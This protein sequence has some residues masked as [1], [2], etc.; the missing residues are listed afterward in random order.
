[1]KTHLLAL[2]LAATCGALPVFAQ[3]AKQPA[4]VWG[5]EESDLKPDPKITFGKLGNGMRY[6]ILPNAEPPQRTSLRLYVDAGSLMEVE[7]QRGLAHF[8]EHM[9]FN[10]TTNFP[11]GK[12]VEYFQRLG[13]SF[14]GDTNA[15]TSFKETVYKLE[16]P[17][18]DEKL[19]REGLQLFRDYADGMLLTQDEIEKERGVILS[20]KL[21][22]DSPDSRTMEAAFDFALPDSIIS[23]RLPIGT[24][25]VI[26]GADRDTFV[27]F[28]K[29]W[30]TSD[31]MV[32]VA[33]G[34]VEADKLGPLIE[35]YFSSMKAPSPVVP[36][37]D[38]GK[39]TPGRGAITKI[40]YE[41]EASSTD[42]GIETLR[43]WGHVADTSEQR[44]KDLRMGIA[45][46]IIGRRL[47]KLA[48]EDGAPFLRGSS[49][50]FGFLDFVRFGGIS[51]TCKPDTWEG[52]LQVAEQELRRALQH[53][54]TAAEIDEANAETMSSYRDAAKGAETR[55]SRDLADG[56]VDEVADGIVST[57]PA[58]NLDWVE[59][60]I[61]QVTAA[62]C[63]EE[64]RSL[65]TNQ[66]DVQ[67]FV[68]GNLKLDE[69]E[70]KIAEA[71]KKS[72]A[73]KVEP[74][75]E[76]QQKAFAYAKFGEPGK[77]VETKHHEDLGLTQLRFANNVRLNLKQT[78]FEKDSIHIA[79]RI[80]SGSLTA[81]P[82]RP[83][84][85][86]VASSVFGA[87][88]LVEHSADELQRIFAGNVVGAS[89]S[90]EEDAF[91]LGGRTNREDL[92]LEC[93]LLAA[94]LTA[95]GYREEA[96]RQFQQQ[97]DTLYTQLAHT[98]QGVM[99]NEVAQYMAGGDFRFGFPTQEELQKRTLDEVKAWLAGPL[100]TGYLEIAVVGDF[101]PDKAIAAIGAT[102]GALPERAAEKPKLAEARV[103]KFPAG[104]AKTFEFESEIKKGSSLVYWPTEDIWDIGR[105][106]RLSV[107][108]SVLDDR[109]RA[110]VREELGEAYSPY[111]R[112]IPSATYNGFGK[113]FSMVTV[114][115]AQAQKI[116]DVVA[117]IGNELFEKGIGSDEL[118]RAVLPLLTS[119]ERQL[120]TNDYWLQTVALS[121]QEFPQRLDW[122]RN[123]L[124]DY[125]SIT[126]QE[127][128]ALAKQYLVDAKAVK[129]QV[130]PEK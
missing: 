53:G 20:E 123:M 22:R 74:P 54:F 26:K 102:F 83:G 90:V 55:L 1:M 18:P 108:G 94:Y 92:L 125:K 72:R 109:L 62:N 3:E 115:P 116:V 43:P 99:A 91:E 32:L 89:F 107:L 128:N 34:A 120:R 10:G 9:A 110:K 87:G 38:L 52:A 6:L 124:D 63:L 12:M 27:D 84:L 118:E 56:L 5:Q 49:Y 4:A 21:T 46:W 14:G 130:V 100:A 51:V 73:T 76:Q 30:Y 33:V 19:L 67:I 28:Y 80:G 126:V 59:K 31:R 29:K 106:R 112:N 36:D 50:E 101:D 75:V 25:E 8:I 96:L 16:L 88:G 122:A 104:G 23:K 35:E 24:K 17:K 61:G 70:K 111:A 44:L 117:G 65:W 66:D 11:G 79:M 64:L 68:G 47:E 129:V 113:M 37:P 98:A 114:E 71:F 93:Q 105:T 7:A 60:A 13:M 41:K 48:K 82:D 119:I 40:H 86:M 15:H 97:L 45:N 78:D 85:S 42:I 121:S 57:S 127:V 95:P 103:L 58:Q 69:G 77:V 39:V 81:P 2:L